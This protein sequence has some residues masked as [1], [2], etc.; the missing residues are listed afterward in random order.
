MRLGERIN[1]QFFSM[2]THISTIY[3]ILNAMS[4]VRRYA[5]KPQ[6]RQKWYRISTNI[7][8]LS[9]K[10]TPLCHMT[11]QLMM[12]GMAY[13]NSSDIL[14]QSMQGHYR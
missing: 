3:G 6:H 14:I 9:Y 11:Y 5:A 7:P 1:S 4:L 8:G 13:A 2:D 12:F 10:C